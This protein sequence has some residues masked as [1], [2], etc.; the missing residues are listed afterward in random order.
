VKK[1]QDALSNG[2]EEIG[3]TDY[4][5]VLELLG[6]SLR[7][8]G[9]LDQAIHYLSEAI[10][11]APEIAGPYIELGRCYQEQ[12]QYEK[13]IQMLENAIQIAPL[14][15]QG[16]YIS[17][18]VFKETKD[19]ENAE[20]MFRQAAKLAPKNLNIHRQLGAVTAINLVQNH[21]SQEDFGYKTHL[22]S[23]VESME[24]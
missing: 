4:I 5:L 16:Y 6:L 18:L 19:F 17:G 24:P 15:P 22:A 20:A 9:Q 7:K 10:D 11:Q 23:P 14:N 13:A 1:A 21:Q 2:I 3:K 12:R 8:T